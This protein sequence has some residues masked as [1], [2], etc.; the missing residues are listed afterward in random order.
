MT[1]IQNSTQEQWLPIR[2]FENRYKISNQGQIFSFRKNGILTPENKNGYQFLRVE[3]KGKRIRIA[4]HRLV[5]IHFIPNPDNK[6]QIN[7]INSIKNDNRLENLEWCTAKE[8]I[9][10]SVKAGTFFSEKRLKYTDSKKGTQPKQLIGHKVIGKNNAKSIPI[11]LFNADRVFIK[12]YESQ[13]LCAI[14]LKIKQSKMHKAMTSGKKYKGYF[15]SK[16][17][18]L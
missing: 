15:F 16:K 5:A 12:E 2:N 14:D 18:Y 13:N 11:F 8:N 17:N 7:H 10:H 6:P 9:Q 4:I 3:E 1:N